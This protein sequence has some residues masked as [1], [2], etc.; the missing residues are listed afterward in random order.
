M[1]WFWYVLFAS[2]PAFLLLGMA[3]YFGKEVKKIADELAQRLSM[4]FLAFAV[5]AAIV[6]LVCLIFK[7][8]GFV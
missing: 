4:T 7:G 6:G 8:I 1:Y 5:F 2:Q 3:G